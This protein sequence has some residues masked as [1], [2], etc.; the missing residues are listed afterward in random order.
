MNRDPLNHIYL[1]LSA[2]PEP[3]IRRPF[4]WVE[5]LLVLGAAWALCLA[6]LAWHYAGG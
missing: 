6:T 5:S 1:A 4:D 2:L 3:K